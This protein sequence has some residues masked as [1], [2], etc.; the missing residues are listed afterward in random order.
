MRL[1][2]DLDQGRKAHSTRRDVLIS[3]RTID[4]R[5]EDRFVMGS[6]SIEWPRYRLVGST[7]EQPHMQ[8]RLLTIPVVML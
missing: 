5:F 7:G 6:A 3:A 1:L 4:L 2:H 8:R